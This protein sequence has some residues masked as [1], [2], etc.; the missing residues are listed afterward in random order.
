MWNYMSIAPHN[1][2]NLNVQA[3]SV[4]C[5]PIYVHC[6]S[7]LCEPKCPSS[8]STMWT[9]MSIVPHNYVNLNVQAPS[10]PILHILVV[11]PFWNFC[12]PKLCHFQATRD[13]ILSET[14]FQAYLLV[15]G[16]LVLIFNAYIVKFLRTPISIN[17]YIPSGI[18]LEMK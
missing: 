13:F 2:V 9:Y 10:E 11:T 6:I 17:C 5:E 8:I 18:N 14:I 4:L 3:P 1:Y 7:Q 12:C 15:A 16:F